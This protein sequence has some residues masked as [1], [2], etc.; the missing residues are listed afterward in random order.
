M[1]GSFFSFFLVQDNRRNWSNGRQN[2]SICKNSNT[3]NKILEKKL[4]EKYENKRKGTA[5]YGE[6]NE[7]C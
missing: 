3:E 5:A 7:S 4:N 6:K 1:L 2:L